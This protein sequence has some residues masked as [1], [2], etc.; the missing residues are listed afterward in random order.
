MLVV[1]VNNPEKVIRI[2]TQP[3]SDKTLPECFSMSEFEWGT[4]VSVYAIGGL[5]GGVFGGRICQMIG[6]KSTL[7]YNNFVQLI[8]G[9]LMAL[10]INM[11]MLVA[12]RFVIGL[13]CGIAT[14]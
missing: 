5:L 1:V 8:G 3:S 10:A 6:R 11:P 9:A 2:C 13:A 14:V 12:A 4:V 7:F